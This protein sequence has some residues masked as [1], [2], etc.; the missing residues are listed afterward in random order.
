MIIRGQLSKK[1]S[2]L[3]SFWYGG[4]VRR[5]RIVVILAVCVLV[6]ICV[7]AFWPRE[8]EPEYN[9]KKLSEWLALQNDHPEDVDAAVRAIRTNALPMLIKWAEFQLPAW[10]YRLVKL[11]PKLPSPLDPPA[12][13]NFIAGGQRRVFRPRVIKRRD[14]GA[15]ATE[16]MG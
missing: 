1:I 4:V 9:G 13:G 16:G 12:D 2:G 8:H 3:R 10:R 7:V 15:E 5:R 11:Y 6:V 14:G